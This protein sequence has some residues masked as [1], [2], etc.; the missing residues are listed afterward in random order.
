MKARPTRISFAPSSYENGAMW[1][2]PKVP[3]NVLLDKMTKNWP[4]GGKNHKLNGNNWSHFSCHD[5][6]MK[7]CLASYISTGIDRAEVCSNFW[8]WRE[9]L[10]EKELFEEGLHLTGTNWSFYGFP[11]IS[12]ESKDSKNFTVMA[13]LFCRRFTDEFEARKQCNVMWCSAMQ[14]N[15]AQC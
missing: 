9:G 1:T 8:R 11:E 7:P 2:G 13:F 5:R 4:I 10:F 3:N 12:T 14:C 6:N 15:A